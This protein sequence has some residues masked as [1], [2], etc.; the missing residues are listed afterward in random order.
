MIICFPFWSRYYCGTSTSKR[1]WMWYLQDQWKCLEMFLQLRHRLSPSLDWQVAGTQD[2]IGWITHF[3][4]L[5]LLR[6]LMIQLEKRPPVPLLYR[7]K[8]KQC[9][10]C[11]TKFTASTIMQRCTKENFIYNTLFS[12]LNTTESNAISGYVH[13]KRTKN[14]LWYAF[15]HAWI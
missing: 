3:Q 6:I 10:Y 13:L 5:G 15:W 2:W 7:E 12:I 11:G 14:S 8:Y 9:S 4:I 1:T